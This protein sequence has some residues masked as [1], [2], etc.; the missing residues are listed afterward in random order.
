MKQVTLF[1]LAV[2]LGLNSLCRAED[3]VRR[4]S[5][6]VKIKSAENQIEIEFY[7]KYIAKISLGYAKDTLIDDKY[8]VILNPLENV[9]KFSETEKYYNIETDSILISVEKNTLVADAIDKIS[10]DTLM[11]NIIYAT[12]NNYKGFVCKVDADKGVYGVGTQALKYNKQNHTLI[13]WN[14]ASYGYT[15]PSVSAH[16]NIPLYFIDNKF[17]VFVDNPSRGYSNSRDTNGIFAF[18]ADDLQPNI[19]IINKKG[20]ENLTTEISELTGYQPILPH[21]AFGFIQSRNYNS[22][23]HI[24]TVVNNF[25]KFRIPLEAVALDFNWFDNHNGMGNIDWGNNQWWRN[26]DQLIQFLSIKKIK[27]ILITEP[28]ISKTSRNYDYAA[29]KNYFTK[30][31]DGSISEYYILGATTSLIDFSNPDATKWFVNLYDKLTVRDSIESWWCDIAEP[32][33][34]NVNSVHYKGNALNLHNIYCNMWTKNLINNIKMLRPTKRNFLISRSGWAGLSRNSA[35]PWTGDCRNTYEAMSIQSDMILSAGVCGISYLHSDIGGFTGR[36]YKDSNIYTRWIQFGTFTPIMKAHSSNI[37][38]PEPYEYGE[39]ATNICRKFIELRYALLPYIYTMSYENSTKGWPL[40]R[41]M[42][43]YEN[44]ERYKS[45]GD[46]YFFGKDI[47]VAP[48]F[49]STDSRTVLF[50]EGSWINYF[51]L[52]KYKGGS[53]AK[54]QADLSTMPLYVRGGAIIPNSVKIM[55]TAYYNTDT[56]ILNYYYDED[57]NN[58]TGY[59]YID[60][61]NNP[62]SLQDK[63][64][65][66]L[67]YTAENKDSSV[68]FHIE[69]NCNQWQDSAKSRVY[70]VNI[71]HTKQFKGRAYSFINN[72]F[73]RFENNINSFGGSSFTT[74]PINGNCDIVIEKYDTYN[75]V[76]EN[77]SNYIFPNPIK[78]EININVGNEVIKEYTLE[79]FNSAGKKVLEINENN[80]I[81]NAEKIKYNFKSKTGRNPLAPGSYFGRLILNGNTLDFRFIKE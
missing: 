71:M 64:Y 54:V 55:N 7:K 75:A 29:Q 24:E 52:E 76:Q 58:Y 36:E 19:Y 14:H 60:D 47:L 4:D 49:D 39:T 53:D 18:F 11:K 41:A 66:I 28:Y 73:C 79:I 46:Q 62:N 63:Q 50:P 10:G 81:I 70:A 80:P 61:G 42:N 12:P 69:R 3:I 78:D 30:N 72:V 44:T 43:F 40:C 15:Y 26:Y 38:P 45:V 6:S 37:L 77:K 31:P 25:N 35:C 56:L 23:E 74:L 67:K 20:Q 57:V 8:G 9:Y 21:W 34:H 1:T 48:I 22:T 51:D 5:K 59:M 65:E 2:I 33:F 32:E 13:L 27:K 68:V 16:I 17:G